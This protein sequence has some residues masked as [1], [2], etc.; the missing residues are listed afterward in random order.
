MPVSQGVT[1]TREWNSE[2]LRAF[3]QEGLEVWAAEQY[4]DFELCVA[5]S[6]QVEIRLENWKPDKAQATE[7]R[8][9]IGEQISLVME[10]IE[11]EDY[12]SE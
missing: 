5:V 11:A 1:R 9:A 7:V 12:L 4:P 8:Q 2:K 6:R 10:G 3:L